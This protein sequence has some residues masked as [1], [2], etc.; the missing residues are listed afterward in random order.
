MER[1]T[2]NTSSN[3]RYFEGRDSSAGGGAC[4]FGMT[5]GG[6]YRDEYEYFCVGGVRVFG[7]EYFVYEEERTKEVFV[8]EKEWLSRTSPMR[9]WE[10][11][12]PDFDGECCYGRGTG[13]VVIEPQREHFRNG[14]IEGRRRSCYWERLF[15]RR[16]SLLLRD[17]NSPLGS[18]GGL[19]RK[20]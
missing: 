2:P 5:L 8:G 15:S 10:G 6:V 18:I 14:V 7:G 9:K 16:W 20:N 17:K 12:F 19:S 11:V 3:D 4:I 1:C 13:P